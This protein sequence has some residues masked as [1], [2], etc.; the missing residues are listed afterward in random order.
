M[1]W[2]R[3]EPRDSSLTEPPLHTEG[4]DRAPGSHVD[5]AHTYFVWT[6]G[7]QC[8]E[9]VPIQRVGCDW[10]RGATGPGGSG[11]T[12]PV[13]QG[14][15][16]LVPAS[17]CRWVRARPTGDVTALLPT[18][19]PVPTCARG[20]ALRPASALSGPCACPVPVLRASSAH[21]PC[22]RQHVG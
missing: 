7:V 22:A 16:S 8:Q 18:L 3:T 15:E 14:V 13:Q 12:Q 21:R 20:R 4:P 1:R 17:E 2:S 5:M 6:H 19:R 11:E 9:P 10:R